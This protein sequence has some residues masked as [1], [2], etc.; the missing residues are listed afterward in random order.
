VAQS[1]KSARHLLGALDLETTEV[2]PVFDGDALEDLEVDDR[3]RAREIIE[4][5]MIAANGVVARYLASKTFPSLRRVVRTP[6]RWDRIVE[7]AAAP[8]RRP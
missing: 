5:F 2:R 7:L 3:N 8:G 1:L 6:T 4:E